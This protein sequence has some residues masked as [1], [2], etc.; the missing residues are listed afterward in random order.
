MSRIKNFF[1]SEI[2]YSAVLRTTLEALK[3]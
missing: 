1:V 2:D 3:S